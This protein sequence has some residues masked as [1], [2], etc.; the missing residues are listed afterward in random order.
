MGMA[1]FFYTNLASLIPVI[2]WH[3]NPYTVQG[4]ENRTASYVCKYDRCFQNIAVLLAVYL[5][6]QLFRTLCLRILTV[7]PQPVHMILIVRK[8]NTLHVLHLYNK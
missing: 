4:C 7:L 5:T 2:Q 3:I 1:A 6:G 8:N